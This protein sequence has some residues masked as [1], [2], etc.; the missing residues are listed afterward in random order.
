M[1]HAA[2]S[3]K[4]LHIRPLNCCYEKGFLKY[5]PPPPSPPPTPANRQRL[6]LQQTARTGPQAASRPCGPRPNPK[7]RTRRWGSSTQRQVR[8]SGN[9]LSSPQLQE[10]WQRSTLVWPQKKTRL[11]PKSLAGIS[12]RS[13]SSNRVLQSH[14]CRTWRK[15]TCHSKTEKQ[16][17]QR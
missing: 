13:D 10:C 6:R 5:D 15:R 16:I 17:M 4:L 1:F 9:A 8:L 2:E 12:Q 11:S 3:C 7:M 14:Q